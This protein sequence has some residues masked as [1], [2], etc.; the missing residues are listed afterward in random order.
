MIVSSCG[1]KGLK[2]CICEEPLYGD[3]MGEAKSYLEMMEH[4][5]KTIKDAWE[6]CGERTSH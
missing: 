5:A 2:I 6:A 1:S 3:A 4:N